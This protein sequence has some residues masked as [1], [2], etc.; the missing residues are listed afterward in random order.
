VSKE[1]VSVPVYVYRRRDGSTFE[2]QQRM[3]EDAL[4]DCPTTGQSVERVL[5]PFAP[6]Y[7]GTGFYSTDHR[8][9]RGQPQPVGTVGRPGPQGDGN[10]C[11]V[12]RA[13]ERRD[14]T[15]VTPD[16]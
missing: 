9:P 13:P 7:T 6:H 10:R 16:R 15:A 8:T 4:V 3:A 14:V 1:P 2:T 5:Q 12:G 11:P